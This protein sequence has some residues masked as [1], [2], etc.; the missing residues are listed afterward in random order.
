MKWAAIEAPISEVTRSP[1]G[2]LKLSISVLKKGESSQV[3]D[4]DIEST[5]DIERHA[6]NILFISKN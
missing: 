1:R 5:E 2:Y 4:V 6:L 3:P